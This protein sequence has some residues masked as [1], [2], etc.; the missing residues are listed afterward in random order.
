MNLEEMTADRDHWKANHDNQVEMMQRVRQEWRHK[1]CEDVVR[2]LSDLHAFQ[3]SV[4]GSVVAERERQK[5]SWSI[6]H[7]DALDNQELVKAAACWAC[8]DEL[9]R[10]D[11]LSPDFTFVRLWPFPDNASIKRCKEQKTRRE[12]L[13]I[14]GS[15]IVAEIERLD[16]V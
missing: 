14:A 2:I 7:D 11:S 13:V 3:D 5:L 12:E 6:P 15:L 4:V 10:H 9:L 16:R 1:Y 8:S